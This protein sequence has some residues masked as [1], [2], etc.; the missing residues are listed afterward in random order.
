MRKY[1][2]HAITLL[3]VRIRKQVLDRALSKKWAVKPIFDGMF[4]R[5]RLTK[6]ER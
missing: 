6:A 2:D 5:P 3:L 1:S 4:Y